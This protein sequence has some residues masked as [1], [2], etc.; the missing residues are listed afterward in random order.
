MK[1]SDTKTIQA[2]IGVGFNQD[3]HVRVTQSDHYTILMGSESEHNRMTAS[4]ML[5]EERLKEKGLRLKDLTESAF[6]QLIEEIHFG[7]L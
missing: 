3:G 7:S 1:S 2:I 5:I 4:C 6:R